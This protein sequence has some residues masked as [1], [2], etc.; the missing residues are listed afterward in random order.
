MNHQIRLMLT[1]GN[2]HPEVI[3]TSLCEKTNFRHLS[4]L[5]LSGYSIQFFK[6]ETFKFFDLIKI[7]QHSRLLI[8]LCR[9]CVGKSVQL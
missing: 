5:L 1:C 2:G 9:P 6:S 8:L 4:S 7:P 3:E